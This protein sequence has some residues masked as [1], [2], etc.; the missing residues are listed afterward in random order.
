MWRHGLGTLVHHSSHSLFLMQEKRSSLWVRRRWFNLF[1][2]SFC[3]CSSSRQGIIQGGVGS[4]ISSLFRIEQ[5]VMMKW[6]YC[7]ELPDQRWWKHSSWS[8]WDQKGGMSG[9]RIPGRHEPLSECELLEK[10]TGSSSSKFFNVDMMIQFSI[11]PSENN[12]RYFLW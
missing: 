4:S 5:Y 7:D 2:D 11:N 8:K 1:L 12:I 10:C 9:V 6:N 3:S